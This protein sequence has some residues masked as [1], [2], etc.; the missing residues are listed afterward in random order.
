LL[1]GIPSSELTGGPPILDYRIERFIIT[2]ND[3][4]ISIPSTPNQVFNNIVGP[5]YEDRTDIRINGV[6][7]LYRIYSRTSV[8]LSTLF[9]SVTAI[10]SRKSDIVYGVSSAVN[11]SRITLSWNPPRFIESGLPIV[12]YYIQYRLFTFTSINQIPRENIIGTFTNL[13][14]ITNTINDMNSIL[15]NDTLWSSLDNNNNNNNTSVISEVYTKSANLFYTITDLFNNSAYLFRIAAVTQDTSRRNLIGLI[16]V[17]GNNSPYL[18]RPTIIGKVP[19]RIINPEYKIG[20]ENINITW[21]GT[22]VSN[23]ESIIRFIVDYRVF[24]SSAGYLT[25]TFDY[26]NSLTFNNGVDTVLFSIT[27]TGLETNVTSRPLTNTD[28]YEMIVYAENAV[29]YTNVIDRIILNSNK[30]FDDVYENLTIPR[31]VRPTS[32]PSLIVEVRE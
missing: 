24:G 30:Q 9:N 15:V 29:G 17:I 21:S 7:F 11:T 19:D 27:V 31:L 2:R 3:N 16:K 8:G 32:I 23:T 4:S 14:T 20:S 26:I 1:G 13:T 18:S 28:S 6:E 25:Q 5:Y 10:P 22:N 12:Q